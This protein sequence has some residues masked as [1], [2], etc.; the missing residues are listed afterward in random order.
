MKKSTQISLLSAIFGVGLLFCTGCGGSKARPLTAESSAVRPSYTDQASRIL[1]EHTLAQLSQQDQDYRLGPGDVIEVNIFEWELSEKAKT[2]PVRVSQKGLVSLPM[3]GDLQ[4]SGETVWELKKQIEERLQ[5]G[6]YIRRPQVSVII[7]EFHSKKIAVVGSVRK[8][9]VYVIERNVTTLLDILSLAGG[10][11]D[12]AGQILY[13]IRREPSASDGAT[14]AAKPTTV[15]IDLHEL[16]ERCN[17]SLNM[18]LRHGDIVSVPQAERFFVYGYVKEPGAFSLTKPTTVL[19]AIAMAQGVDLEKG[20]PSYCM[21]KR[22][23]SSGEEELIPV[24]LEAIRKGNKPNLYLEPN[25][26]IDVRQT[27]LKGFGVGMGKIFGGIGMG[28]GYTLN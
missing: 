6:G 19:E 22:R 8:P 23:S 3:I 18:V 28:L 21:L 15:T 20:S 14:S 7:K 25:D 17:L 9:A 4:A 12:R 27:W 5:A 13:V 1:A 2:V 10:L 16:M 26:I 24:D 11:S